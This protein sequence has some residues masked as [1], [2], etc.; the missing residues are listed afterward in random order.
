MS[1]MPRILHVKWTDHF[2]AKV[3]QRELTDDQVVELFRLM[4]SQNLDGLVADLEPGERA[5][6]AL[7]GREIKAVVVCRDKIDR[8]HLVVMTILGPREV[9]CLAR[10]TDTVR[11]PMPTH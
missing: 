11:K 3:R 8:T 7:A 2:L 1:T 4:T 9:E 5:A 10:R 6:I